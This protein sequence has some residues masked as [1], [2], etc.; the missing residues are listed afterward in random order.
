MI[1][2]SRKIPKNSLKMLSVNWNEPHMKQALAHAQ[3]CAFFDKNMVADARAYANEYFLPTEKGGEKKI[4]DQLS[5]YL[6][7]TNQLYVKLLEEKV[8]DSEKIHRMIT[9]VSLRKN[10]GK[11]T[12]RLATFLNGEQIGDEEFPL[13]RE[14]LELPSDIDQLSDEEFAKDGKATTQGSIIPC[15]NWD[16][17]GTCCEFRYNGLPWN[18][19][20]KY[21]WC[22]ANCGNGTPVNP[23]DACCRSHDYCYRAYPDYPERCNC[24]KNL[25]SCASRTDEAGTDRV[26]AAFQI[27]MAYKGC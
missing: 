7:L 12:K 11:A 25:I 4:A 18:P 5:L 15:F 3:Q 16:G 20:V 13:E 9:V 24:D 21:N 1:I 27:K 8:V 14:V 17:S 10:N 22:G 26:I 6:K 2:K 23:L 19:L